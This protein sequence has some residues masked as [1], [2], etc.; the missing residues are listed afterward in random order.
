MKKKKDKAHSFLK[1]VVT[2]CLIMM[3][4]ITIGVVALAWHSG[5]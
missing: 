2:L 4:V 5:E 3:C 1:R